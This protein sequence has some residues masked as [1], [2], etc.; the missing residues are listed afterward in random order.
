MGL[1]PR[2]QRTRRPVVRRCGWVFVSR[3]LLTP[4]CLAAL[5][6]ASLRRI[7]RRAF[8]RAASSLFLVLLAIAVIPYAELSIVRSH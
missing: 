6:A 4:L 8:K 1:A 7:L 2:P 3:N 5:W